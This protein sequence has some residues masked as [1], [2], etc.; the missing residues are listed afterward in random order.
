MNILFFIIAMVL[1]SGCGKSEI[2][3]CVEAQIKSDS[4]FCKD[5]DCVKIWQDV[6][7]GE[8]RKICLEAAAGK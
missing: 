4:Y 6:N 5:S 2:D 7:E 8:Y 3:K 1:L